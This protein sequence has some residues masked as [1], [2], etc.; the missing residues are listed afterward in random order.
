MTQPGPGVMPGLEPV[1]VADEPRPREE[2]ASWNGAALHTQLEAFLA[3]ENQKLIDFRRDLHMHPELGY[4]EHRTT[5][6]IVRELTAAGLHPRVLPKG[7]G[8]ICD[9]GPAD[10]PTVALRAD[11]DALP[12]MDEKDVPY[13]ST[14]PGVAHAC[15]HDVHTT[16]VLGTGLFLAQQAAA[17]LLPGRVRLLFQP[18]E[19]HPG[20]AL[21]VMAAGGLAGVDRVFALHCDPR[22]EVGQLGLRAGPIT[23]ACDKVY[24]K[25][26]GPG[27][28]TARPHLTADLVYALAKIVT[29]LPAALSRRVDP[30]S[31]LSLVW[32]RVA[33]GSVANAIPDDGIAEGT[34]RCLDDEAWHKA[35]EMMKALL[36]SV[37]AAYDVEASLEYVRGVPPTVNDPDSVQMFRDAATRMLGEDAPVPT[38]QSLGGEDFGWY[39]ESIPGALARL[40]VR[41]PGSAEEY[42]LHRGDFDVDERCIGVG[43]RVL[44]ATAL[45]ALWEGRRSTGAEV[46]DAVSA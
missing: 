46:G 44:T 28:H 8:V 43:V 24:V 7:T 29:E 39:L 21:D 15:G 35:P 33:A 19:E 41:T 2:G 27:G 30:R 36:D 18:A 42:D 40:G 45:T 17:G 31:S 1:A 25:V 13:R 16:I 3:R 4:A 37:A 38:P 6:Q 10:G 20:G 5:Q 22:I 32:G 34:V 26:T 23:A 14:V 9:I 11:I 12:L